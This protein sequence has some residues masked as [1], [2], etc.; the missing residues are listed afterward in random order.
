MADLRVLNCDEQPDQ[1]FPQQEDYNYRQ[2]EYNLVEFDVKYLIRCLNME[3]ST[4]YEIVGKPD[5]ENRQSPQPD[6]LIKDNKTGSLIAIEHAR[7]FESEK[8]REKIANSV[9]KSPFGIMF[10]WIDFSNS[11]AIREKAFRIHF[12]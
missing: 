10:R 4:S 12:R 9:K 7:F 5:A 8:A 3:R 2:E 6:F 11:R 1:P